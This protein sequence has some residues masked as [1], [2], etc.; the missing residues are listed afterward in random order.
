MEV[1]IADLEDNLDTR[2]LQEVDEK[3]VERLRKSHEA[4]RSLV[5]RRDA[6]QE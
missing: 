4:W 3:G 2:R 5:A 1:K 6:G